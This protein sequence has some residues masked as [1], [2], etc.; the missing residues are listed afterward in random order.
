M[1]IQLHEYATGKDININLS[2]IDTFAAANASKE[3][4][5]III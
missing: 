5:G 1:I 4:E 3:D 2:R